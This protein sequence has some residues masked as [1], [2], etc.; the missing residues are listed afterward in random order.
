MPS[1]TI[2][3]E[4]LRELNRAFGQVSK[5][6]QK[7]LRT[8]LKRAAEPV[9]AA[10]R[11]KGMRFGARTAMGYVAGSR[12]GGAVVRQRRRKTTGL[13]PDFG[14][15]QMRTVLEPALAENEDAVVREVRQLLDRVIDG[16]GF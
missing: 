7:E 13:R 16:A 15:L 6:L 1:P 12:A 2:Q 8:E 9:A 4:G 10:A 11:V 14:V 5:E 3:V